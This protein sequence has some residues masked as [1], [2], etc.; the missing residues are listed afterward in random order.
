[1]LNVPNN[2]PEAA[3]EIIFHAINPETKLNTETL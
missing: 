2:F 3:R 1:M